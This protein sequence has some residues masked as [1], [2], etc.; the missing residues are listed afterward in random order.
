MLQEWKLDNQVFT[1]ILF[2]LSIGLFLTCSVFYLLWLIHTAVR[3]G[4]HL[5]QTVENPLFFLLLVGILLAAILRPSGTSTT[6]GSAHWATL[7]ELKKAQLIKPQDQA[8]K[9]LLSAPGAAAS[10]GQSQGQAAPES[11]LEVGRRGRYTIALTEQQQES[12]VLVIA[13]TGKR[14][15]S[16]IFIPALLAGERGHRSMLVNDVKGELYE[17]CA[18]VVSR[19]HDVLLFSPTK[20]GRSNC[21]NPLA[22]IKTSKEARDFARAWVENTGVS[23][24]EFYNEASRN[25]ITAMVLHLIDTETHPAL[26]RLA[27]LIAT[28][29]LEEIKI[30]LLA[31]RSDRARNTAQAFLQTVEANPKLSSGVGLGAAN[32]FSILVDSP[33]YR[34]V[35]AR[36]EIDFTRMI[37]GPRSVALFINVPASAT[38]DLKPL[39]SC[40]IM[41][42]MNFLTQ[43]AERE[44]GGRLTRSFVLYL[45][46][47]A[48]AG[49]IPNLERHITLIRGAGMAV[50]GALQDM[51]QA[52]RVYGPE[53]TDT[54]LSNFTTQI[55][56]PGLGQREAEYYSRRIGTA[57]VKTTT[58]SATT[59]G[60][61]IVASST[62][63]SE[64]ETERAL[65][66]PE[67]IRQMPVGSFVMISDN[68]APVRGEFRTYI[69]R[70]ELQALLKLPVRRLRVRQAAG[71]Q[72]QPGGRGQ[73]ITPPET[74]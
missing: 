33:E 15:S 27:D 38:D 3:G 41:Q 47:L 4:L 28:R 56:L 44:P 42:L 25:L 16:G 54:L 58:R 70:Q 34:E 24:E 53:I 31:S 8:H 62:T 59:S 5:D 73:V 66:L 13:P 10:N 48:N 72:L 20:P 19:Y 11:L 71:Q 26:S 36:D 74:L 35:T 39:T 51:G 37:D 65:L 12:H 68:T 55:A 14:K 21:Y 18:G 23:R 50:I 32:R 61:S 22:H 57:T 69:E 1:W 45:D 40:L 63:K 9:L 64:S 46:E 2:L 30:L 43:R 6:R 60:G 49:R 17:L 29:S 67:E 52:E 7:T